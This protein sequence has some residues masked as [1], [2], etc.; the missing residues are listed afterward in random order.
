VGDLMRD[1]R[2]VVSAGSSAA[3][4]A[5]CFGVPVISIGRQAGLDMNPLLEVDCR[6]WTVA[7]DP[8]EFAQAIAGWSPVHPL[9][10]AER[11]AIGE[12]IRAEYF[13]PVSEAGMAAFDPRHEQQ[14]EEVA[15]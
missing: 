11:I 14:F 6:L 8:D 1:A 10:L 13:E 3:L 5:I 4:E 2:M 15:A 7:Y 12:A 9:P